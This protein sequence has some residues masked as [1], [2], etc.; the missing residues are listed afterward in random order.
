M[1]YIDEVTE[2]ESVYFSIMYNV[3]DEFQCIF[4]DFI[5]S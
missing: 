1:K 2:N 4:A 5:I 3:F